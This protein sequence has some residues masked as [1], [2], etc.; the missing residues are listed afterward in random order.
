MI[1]SVRSILV[2]M[3]PAILA[4]AA[5]SGCGGRTY[6]RGLRRLSPFGVRVG[7]SDFRDSEL[8]AVEDRP[9]AGVYLRTSVKGNKVIELAADAA[10]DSDAPA[11]HALYS[12]GVSVL[13]F[14]TK[15]GGV[16]LHAGGGAMSESTE[17]N[18]YVDGYVSAGAGYSM[19]AGS[20]RLDIRATAQ[21]M[22][23]SANVTRA[24][25]CTMGYGF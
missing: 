21:Q 16:Y 11:E 20:T 2:H 4:L 25:V 15:H 7:W 13:Y 12:A 17:L 10:M 24:F 9:Q 23:D 3:A 19:P 18:E 14:P 1:T 8:T 5:A 22:I 6:G